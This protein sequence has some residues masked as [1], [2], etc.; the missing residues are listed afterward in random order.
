VVS[1]FD[2]GA[3]GSDRPIFLLSKM[4][5]RFLSLPARYPVNIPTELSRL[6]LHNVKLNE[7]RCSD[8]LL[9]SCRRCVAH[10]L[11]FAAFLVTRAKISCTARRGATA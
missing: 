6:L 1:G 10:R 5:R 7:N 9:F 3:V 8:S 11:A 2:P 4:E